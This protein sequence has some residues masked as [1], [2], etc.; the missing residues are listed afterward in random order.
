MATISS[1]V[2][3]VLAYIFRSRVT[4]SPIVPTIRTR[5]RKNAE[6]E[7]SYAFLFFIRCRPK[8]TEKYLKCFF[9]FAFCWTLSDVC[10][11][12]FCA[13]FSSLLF[14]TTGNFHSI[15]FCLLNE[16]R[17]AEGKKNER[18]GLNNLKSSKHT[19]FGSVSH[20]M[21][22]FENRFQ[23]LLFLFHLLDIYVMRCV[24]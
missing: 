4:A 6:T 24:Y 18:L 7:V 19:P 2:A 17:A 21:T 20:N 15:L 3:T 10:L 12:L 22:Y 16:T 1:S 14:E 9:F 11:R 23:F 8:S 13:F 5:I